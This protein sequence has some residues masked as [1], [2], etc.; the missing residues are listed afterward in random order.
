MLTLR[1]LIQ[2]RRYCNQ[3]AASNGTVQ[4]AYAPENWGLAAAYNYSSGD[5]GAGGL[6]RTNSTFLADGF[7]DLGT[8]SSVGLSAWWTPEESGWIPSVSTGW[9]LNQTSLKNVVSAT[10]L[11]YYVPV[12][13]RWTSMG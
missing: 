1:I 3:C 12:L 2:F 4:I 6:G 7:Y 9:G 11:K 10:T 5:N 13:V 8:T